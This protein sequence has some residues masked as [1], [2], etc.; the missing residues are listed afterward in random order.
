MIAQCNSALLSL[1]LIVAAQT[2]FAQ[3]AEW[4]HFG[5]NGANNK[6]SPLDE[7]NREN[8]K[9]LEIAWS[10]ESIDDKVTLENPRVQPGQFKVT[11]LV[12]DGLIY[13]STAVNQIVAIDA[14]TGETVWEY[15]PQSYA[16]GRPANIG[17]Q[18][19]GVE[20][21]SDGDEARIFCATQDR[22]LIALDA[23][24]GKPA[25]E[26]GDNGV[27][28]LVKSLGQRIQ[29]RHMTHTS[30]PAV[31]NDTII[32]GSIIFDRPILKQ[33]LPGHVRGFDVRTGKLKW[34]FHTIPQ[35]G[36]FGNETWE[37]GSAEYTGAANVWSMFAIDEK[38]NYVYLPTSTP[39]NDFYGGHRLGDNLFAES[40]VCLNAET[41]E[42]VWHFQAVHHGVWDYD[43]PTAP[44]LVDV[45]VD[46]KVVPLLAQ[47]SKQAFT[48]VFNRET[49]KPIWPIEER[50][51]PQST[52]PGERTSP[53]QPFPTKP[54]PFDQQGFTEDD[55]IDFT[56]ELREKALE[57]LSKHK[58][59]P[60]YTPPGLSTENNGVIQMPGDG[61][62]ANWMG[63]A[64]DPETGIMYI[65]SST[66]PS[67]LSLAPP[68]PNRSNF[69]YL[70]SGVFG[71]MPSLGGLPLNKPPYARVTAIDLKTGDHV[72]MTPNGW[73]PVDHRALKD[74]NLG[75]LGQSRGGPLVTK[76]LLLVNQ[77]R[78]FG[79]KNSPRINV[80]DKATGELLGHIPLPDNPYGNPITFSVDGR[81]HLAVAVGGGPYMT[82]LDLIP[83]EDTV[84][85]E[86]VIA[87]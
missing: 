21:W 58:L 69:R 9:D 24:T 32:V 86:E 43:F 22:K 78:G 20:Y 5:G 38:L 35:K 28:D 59:G 46:G 45:T 63:A 18:H 33:G 30:P 8:F 23:K 73:G 76:T 25:A 81:Q 40:I 17:W 74:L 83:I 16:S 80:F 54:A 64:V 19:R 15:D 44:N 41:G 61:G 42:R 55:V 53:T 36:E 4:R 49:G 66:S 14:T 82:G 65:P 48:Y 60:L 7:I 50:A 26:F 11:P 77:T 67:S 71:N 87:A 3:D 79:E 52:V 6:Y 39:T 68:D 56:P 27:I 2:A 75:P 85:S 29:A 72:W 10:W 57:I 70:Q 47:I 12:V 37:N 34:T 1:T 84:V 13:V 62:G 31:C 51:V